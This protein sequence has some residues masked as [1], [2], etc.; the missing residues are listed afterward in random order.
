MYYIFIDILQSL[1]GPDF[2]VR[3]SETKVF[4][5]TKKKELL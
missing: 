4:F 5:L 2:P 1:K 3:F